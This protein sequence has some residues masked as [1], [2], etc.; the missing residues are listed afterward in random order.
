MIGMPDLH[1]YPKPFGPGDTDGAG[2]K[3]TIGAPKVDL[4][5]LLIRETAQ[6]SWDARLMSDE[7]GTVPRFEVRYRKLGPKVRD[8][9]QWNVFGR[10]SSDNLDLAGVLRDPNLDALEI[11]DRG[12]KGLGGPTTNEKPVNSDQVNNYARFVL[13]IGAPPTQ[14]SSGGTYGFGKTA[15]YLASRC[16]TIVIWS[17]FRDE[18]GDIRD[19]FLAS[20]MGD[21]FTKDGRQY[22]GRQ[23]W[24]VPAAEETEAELLRFEPAEEE[25]AKRLGE[26]VFES[27][28]KAG[29]T[30]TSILILSP[31]QNE[32]GELVELCAEAI[33]RNLWPK[34]DSEQDPGRRMQTS[35]LNGD[36][37]I[38]VLPESEILTAQLEC[39][40]EIRS[41][42]NGE[43]I[44]NPLIK[45]VE[46][47]SRR[48]KALLG[49]LALTRIPIFGQERTAFDDALRGVTYM[50][51]DAELV[52]KVE[53]FSAANSDDL[54][55]LGIFKPTSDMDKYFADAEPPAH[56]SW[57]PAGV[58]DPTGRSYVNIALR[59]IKEEVKGYLA[60]DQTS[61]ES[62]EGSSTG[63]LS[64]S[65]ANLAGAV[66]GGRAVPVPSGKRGNSNGGSRRGRSVRVGMVGVQLLSSAAEARRGRQL[67]DLEL[68]L[69]NANRATVRVGQMSLVVDGGEMSGEDLLRLEEWRVGEKHF[70]S[71]SVEVDSGQSF[72]ACM[73]F[74]VGLAINVTFVAEAAS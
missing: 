24:G 48:P 38:E 61:N 29:E 46:I 34:L 13:T 19:R 49:H 58:E 27:R 74:P 6:N 3:R 42:Q 21:S 69:I 73:S 67:V 1:W 70:S 11:S 28:F 32:E 18:G 9:L 2:S 59:R 45:I 66:P 37:E 8:I 22:T 4:L 35:L 15:S 5:N 26:A 33:G 36:E 17:R 7:D 25:D 71:D 65:L 10:G 39:L 56:D 47:R 31:K 50:R 53:Q 51:S 54:P 14:R 43:E 44:G 41:V 16:S 68:E 55:W 12:T 72:W 64:S 23:W 57:D 30:G 63:A 52:I 20:A 60:P 62:I 40:K